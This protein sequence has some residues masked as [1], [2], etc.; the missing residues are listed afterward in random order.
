MAKTGT[1]AIQK[2]M[3]DNQKVL[4]K[5]GYCY[6]LFSAKFLEV[7]YNR[8]G[9]FLKCHTT[10]DPKTEQHVQCENELAELLKKYD[11]IILSE[12]SIWAYQKE[13]TYWA[14]VKK[15]ADNLGVQLKI[16]VYLRRQEDWIESLWNQKIKGYV[17]W[18]V[19]FEDYINSRL[20]DATPLD[21]E[22]ALSKIEEQVGFENIIVRPYD[23]KQFKN[24]SIIEDFMNIFGLELTDEYTIKKTV[25]NR[26]MPYDAV[27]IKR[28]I[29][30]NDLYQ[31]S[32]GINFYKDVIDVAYPEETL[33]QIAE[34]ETFYT[35]ELLNKITA[36]Y[37]SG[38]EVV[39][40][41][42]LD[43]ADGKLFVDRK[44]L[45]KWDSSD[46]KILEESVRIFTGADLYLYNQVLELKE[47]LRKAERWTLYGLLKRIKRK[48][49]KI[50]GK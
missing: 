21:Y 22:K 20:Y 11:N 12:E 35:D 47:E 9:H 8:N 2:F 15:W 28:M 26:S 32:K 23:F 5:H 10:W 6:P 25:V 4:I 19:T 17:K 43:R 31:N 40:R 37:K 30:G 44:P 14:S 41:K 50:L 48:I 38:N 1:S 45:K 49:F 3:A 39:A 33:S 46:Q 42:Y 29:N 13:D 24:G 34:K 27:E 16:I 7:G 18:T 36:E